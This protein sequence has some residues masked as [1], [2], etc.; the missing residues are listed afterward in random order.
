MSPKLKVTRAETPLQ[1]LVCE[2]ATT[3]VGN[4]KERTPDKQGFI[5]KWLKF[6]WTTLGKPVKISD[7]IC[8][9]KPHYKK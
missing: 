5:E 2:Q 4:S 3:Q 8:L 9:H 6:S 1:T 7:L